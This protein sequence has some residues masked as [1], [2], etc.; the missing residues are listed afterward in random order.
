MYEYYLMEY[1]R[2]DKNLQD[3]IARQ[4]IKK[5]VKESHDMFF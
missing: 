4:L 1:K 5:A 2:M 3:R